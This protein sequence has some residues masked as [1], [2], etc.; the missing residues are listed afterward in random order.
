MRGTGSAA[1]AWVTGARP[2]P[3]WRRRLG[4]SVGSGEEPDLGEGGLV[5]EGGVAG[6]GE[7]EAGIVAVGDGDESGGLKGLEELVGPVLADGGEAAV[8]GMS[9][10]VGAV[11][12]GA[13]EESGE[14]PSSEAPVDDLECEEDG[15][16]PASLVG[17]ELASAGGALSALVADAAAPGADALAEVAHDVEL[18]AALG[19]AVASDAVEASPVELSLLLEPVTVRRGGAVAGLRAEEEDTLRRS[20]SGGPCPGGRRGGG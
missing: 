14:A 4:V 5:P 7:F 16:A 11:V 13:E 20:A 10:D 12:L 9:G 18:A 3:P 6:A 8:L 17:G 2:A 15:A 19:P 1:S